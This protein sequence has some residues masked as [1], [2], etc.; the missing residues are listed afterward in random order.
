MKFAVCNETFQDWPFDRAFAF[1]AECGYTGL[2]IAPFTISEYVTDISA[3]RR[4]EVRRQAGEAGLEI[5]GVH[6]LLAKTEGF[7]MTSPDADVRK[8]T[9]EYFGHLARFCAGLGRKRS[10]SADR[11]SSG[12]CCRA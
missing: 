9:S 7:Y 1:A 3:A 11:P 4:A 5:V 8:K 12:I 6:W 10:W 2:E